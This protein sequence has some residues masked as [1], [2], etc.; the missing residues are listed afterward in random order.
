MGP[1][2]EHHG[3]RYF[4]CSAPELSYGEETAFQKE[5]MG[6]RAHL[7]FCFGGWA[8]LGHLRENMKWG[9]TQCELSSPSFLTVPLDC[10]HQLLLWGSFHKQ[11]L[12]LFLWH[13]KIY[14]YLHSERQR[15]FEMIMPNPNISTLYLHYFFSLFFI[16]NIG[17]C[18]TLANIQ[19]AHEKLNLIST[20]RITAKPIYSPFVEMSVSYLHLILSDY[21]LI[22]GLEDTEGQLR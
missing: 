4:S 19:V 10:I 11:D 20:Y 18:K 9:L 14:K 5:R 12:R 8:R 2:S 17:S 7:L 6:C 15:P 13:L 1:G 22:S 3:L 16:P 21:L